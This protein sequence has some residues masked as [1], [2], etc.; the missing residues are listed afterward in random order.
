MTVVTLSPASGYFPDP[1]PIHF[2]PGNI[3]PQSFSGS[4]K[5]IL[6]CPGSSIQAGCFQT[7]QIKVDLGSFPQQANAVGSTIMSIGNNNIYQDNKGTWQM[8]TTL[9]LSNP[10]FTSDTTWSVIA[11][12]HAINASSSVPTKWVV[13]TLLVGSLSQATKANY[14]GKYFEDG[15]NLYLLYSKELQANPLRDGIVAQLMLS[16][17]Q[18]ASSDPVT[19]ID[20]E[21]ANVGFN[22]EYFFG[23]N[24]PSPFKLVETGNVTKI[25]GKY[26][27]AYSTGAY[28]SPGY[29]IGLAWSDAFLPL[30]GKTYKKIH[31]VDS[32]GIWGQPGQPEVLY[33]LQAQKSE[34]P[35]YVGL[36][37]LAPG[38]PSVVKDQSGEYYLYFAAYDPSDAP[39][40]AGTTRF[41]PS[42]RRPYFINLKIAIPANASV[43][44]ASDEDLASWIIAL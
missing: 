13:D 31:K 40:M 42:H 6:S 21:N 35:N 41:D 44:S 39:L 5:T 4:N 18:A 32:T 25:D 1:L 9:H 2:A 38:V 20:P 43:E 19:L 30:Q 37:V 17:V 16:A 8:A 11:H 27:L 24:P 15:G 28:Y 22:S 12:A 7:T 29:K 26:V 36:Q 3:G 10:A 34:W 33:F 23:L 14:N